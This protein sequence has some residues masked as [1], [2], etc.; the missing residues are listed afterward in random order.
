MEDFLLRWGPLL[1]SFVSVAYAI[2]SSRGKAASERVSTLEGK[3][4][5]KAEKDVVAALVGKVD[6]LEDRNSRLE[7]EMRHLPSR[8]QTHELALALRDV[9]GELGVLT[10]KLKPISHTSERLQEWLIDEAKAKRGTA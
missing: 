7:G 10:E 2:A 8:E 5:K 3:L 6:I 1:L 4:E 9:R